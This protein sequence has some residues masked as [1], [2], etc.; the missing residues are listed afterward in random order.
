MTTKTETLM[1]HGCSIRSDG[2]TDS[3]WTQEVESK[4]ELLPWQAAGLS[5]T[6]SGYGAEIPTAKKVKFNGRWRRVYCRIYGNSGTAYLKTGKT[7]RIT[8]TN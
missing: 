8:V 6:A 4:T 7:E 1:L 3:Y 5:Y 2:T